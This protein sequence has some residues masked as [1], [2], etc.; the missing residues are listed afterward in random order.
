MRG[1]PRSDLLMQRLASL[2]VPGLALHGDEGGHQCPAAPGHPS[3]SL[4]N[5]AMLPSEADGSFTRTPGLAKVSMP[6]TEN[7]AVNHLVA[8]KCDQV[9][10]DSESANKTRHAKPSNAGYATEHRHEM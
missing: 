8:R 2:L 5:V 4:L 3:R 6:R 9:A 10:P 7:D 1:V